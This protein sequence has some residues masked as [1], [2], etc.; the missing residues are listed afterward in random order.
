MLLLIHKEERPITKF[1]F[2]SHL[3]WIN[4]FQFF[5]GPNPTKCTNVG[6]PLVPSRRVPHITITFITHNKHLVGGNFNCLQHPFFSTTMVAQ[7]S[8]QLVVMFKLVATFYWRWG[9]GN[10]I[11]RI[12]KCFTRQTYGHGFE[13]DNSFS[14]VNNN[15]WHAKIAS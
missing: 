2:Y 10:V 3:H 5:H 9:H 13:F 11:C 4:Y 12:K 6:V 8:F 14:I 7:P 15:M 1:D